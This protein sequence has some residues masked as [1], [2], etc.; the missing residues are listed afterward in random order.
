MTFATADGYLRPRRR[1]KLEFA[2]D[3]IAA[4]VQKDPDI[5]ALFES[6][7]V[8]GDSRLHEHG[9]R[10]GVGA[11]GDSKV[12]FMAPPGAAIKSLLRC[13]PQTPHA[14]SLPLSRQQTVCAKAC[15]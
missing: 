14:S 8:P 6:R 13:A 2:E 5:I 12:P 4:K 10:S 15:R 7:G 3:A 11:G 9:S 1:P